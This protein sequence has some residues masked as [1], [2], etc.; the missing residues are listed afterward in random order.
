[1]LESSNAARYILYLRLPV[2]LIVRIETLHYYEEK[3]LSLYEAKCIRLIEYILIK[4]LS[5]LRLLNSLR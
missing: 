2:N 5:F 3:A 4:M 1:M